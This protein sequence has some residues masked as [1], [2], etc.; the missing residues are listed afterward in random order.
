LNEKNFDIE[1]SAAEIAE[2]II[3][4]TRQS[5]SEEDLRIRTTNIL[6]T[7]VLERF[8]I[9]WARFEYTLV[10]GGR[11]DALYGHVIIEYESPDTFKTTRGFEKAV[12]QVKKYIT[13]LAGFES[14]YK[15]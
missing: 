4:A 13:D 3:E 7:K 14:E 15:K 10:S 5:L 8:G 1:V 6:R 12:D 2:E 9:P 11:A